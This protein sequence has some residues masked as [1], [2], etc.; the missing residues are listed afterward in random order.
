MIDMASRFYSLHYSVTEIVEMLLKIRSET[1]SLHLESSFLSEPIS[2]FRMSSQ[3][4]PINGFKQE[5]ANVIRCDRI[6]NLA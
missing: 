5:I 1:R 2:L 6:L 3:Y 4:L